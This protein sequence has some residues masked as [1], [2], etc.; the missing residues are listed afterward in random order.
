MKKV[1]IFLLF[2]MVMINN[3][4]AAT[5]VK[6]SENSNSKLMFD[7]QSV[8]EK[9]TLKRAWIKI[10]YKTP[11]KSAQAAD[12]DFNLSKVLWYFDCTAQKSATAQVFQYM[13]DDLIYS[14]AIDP[15]NAEFIEPVPE[16]DIDIAMRQVC[17]KDAPVTTAK[18]KPQAN[19]TDT[20]KKPEAKPVEQ[21]PVKKETTAEA[22]PETNVE[23]KPTIDTKKVTA[24]LIKDKTNSAKKEEGHKPHWTYEGKEGPENWGKLNPDFATCDAGRNQSPI[25]IESTMQASLKPLKLIQRYP[26]KDIVNNGH[27]VQAN[28]KEG[29]MLILDGSAFLMKQVHFHA[30]SENQINGK[31]YPLEAHFVHA[32]SKGNLAVIGV[33]FKEGKANPALESLWLQM[34]HEVGD[35]VDMKS[36]VLASEFMPSNR[37]YY[38][39]SGS[40]TTP[41]CSEG[42]R[43]IV[44]K[45]PITASKEQIAMFEKT[46]KHHNNRPVQPLNG[47]LVIE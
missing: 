37:S 26:A 18:A 23:T 45:N 42:V 17:K 40:L 14:A 3:S 35:P 30:P 4:H 38:R 43:W 22:K 46:V 33:M 24:Q 36:R 41:P 31:S 9:D 11:Q 16:T 5:W 10:V 28:F 39:F 34:P 21:A 25:N 47:R 19:P 44:M 20:A 13:N 15:K 29:N 1:V 12:K 7:K 6:L 32:D 8:L 2:L 27:T